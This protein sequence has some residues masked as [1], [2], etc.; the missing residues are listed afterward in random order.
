MALHPQGRVA[1]VSG[2]RNP[3][4]A[5]RRALAACRGMAQRARLPGNC[6]LY[7][8]GDQVVLPQRL[9]SGAR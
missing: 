1:V 8:V 7:A 5:A 9:A 3:E 6:T 4:D 2:A